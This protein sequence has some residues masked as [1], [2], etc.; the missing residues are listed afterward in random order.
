M[1]TKRQK[2]Y[3]AEEVLEQLFRQDYSSS[4][5]SNNSDNESDSG[6]E[7]FESECTEVIPPTPQKTKTRRR[8]ISTKSLERN[9]SFQ[10]RNNSVSTGIIEGTILYQNIPDKQHDHGTAHA[11]C[12]L[13]A[14]LLPQVPQLAAPVINHP[15]DTSQ[16]D[17]VVRIDTTLSPSNSYAS[18]DH[19]KPADTSI[20]ETVYSI[21][22]DEEIPSVSNSPTILN[23]VPDTPRNSPSPST[24]NFE[25]IEETHSIRSSL[26]V[27][28]INDTPTHSDSE[29]DI[30]NVPD[31]YEIEEPDPPV[32]PE[33]QN[34]YERDHICTPIS[35]YTRDITLEQDE[36]KGWTA[37][38]PDEIPDQGP[39]TETP[40]LNVEMPSKE[41]EDFFNL[42]FDSSMFQTIADK[43]NAYA[44]NRVATIL[45]GR[46]PIEQLNHG[47]NYPNNRMYDYKDVN[48]SDIK[49]FLGH[50][51]LM[52]I[53]RK[54]SVHSYWSKSHM[55][56]T[57][58]FGK[59]ISQN[60]FQSILWH[61]HM[62]DTSE[63]PAVGCP[64]H[65]PLARL[66]NVIT[67]AQQ[68][69]RHSIIPAAD[70]ALDESTC[71]FRGK[72]K[73]LVY[74]KS[75]P[76]KFH[77]KLFMVSEKST[78]YIIGFSVYTG[79]ECNELIRA[80]ATLDPNCTTTTKTVMGLLHNARLLDSHRRVWFDNWFN[81]TELLLELLARN[82]YGAGTQ[83]GNRSGLPQSVVGKTVKLKRFET[84][85]RRNGNLLCL[86]WMDKRPVTMLSSFHH[87]VEVVSK[88]RYNGEVVVK[89]L[90][91]HD[92]NS[93]MN[94][95][96]QS[97]HL[98]SSYFAPK[99]IKWYR[100]LF[101]H[102]FN[103]IV[104][105][106]FILCRQ[107]SQ[108]KLSHLQYKE[109]LAEYLITTA[110]NSATCVPKRPQTPSIWT[111]E[112]L[113][114]HHFPRKFRT[115]ATCKRKVPTKRCRV[116]NFSKQKLLHFGYN[117]I[118]LPVKYTSYTC[119]KCENMPLCIE[120]CFKLFHTENNYRK[121]ALEYRI[122]KDL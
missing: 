21:D 111:E 113:S 77:I 48:A 67:M 25:T 3:T 37:P 44:R 84:V 64:N 115:V 34:F 112:R 103:M 122:S 99:G 94:S 61:L 42:L 27:F 8:I 95:V 15:S 75:K 109:Y 33:G 92:Y 97:D 50:V 39:F 53:I 74:N 4:S 110:L 22:L 81:S 106:A 116:C 46:D 30:D 10:P 104:C 85:Y 23:S 29:S 69:F 105:N 55:T 7:Y 114:P 47:N 73:F 91:I 68:N 38:F 90:V 59:Y 120:P 100:R 87:A 43:T 19:D 86:K 93:N 102:L 88:V 56:R 32:G 40:G 71:A 76:N 20:S 60:K 36:D 72:V 119:D 121:A 45:N 65:D 98:L 52:S 1:A 66:R 17:T 96:D 35:N 118:K 107:H 70:V 9:T 2:H 57:P 117:G 13:S 31:Y 24:S 14:D 108:K 63:N 16:Y 18:D 78:G 83:R 101:F 54:S 80:N 41:P 58:F 62:N 82:T 79:K 49:I 51:L 5:D 12:T 11:Q 6:S 26:P 89:P 28:S